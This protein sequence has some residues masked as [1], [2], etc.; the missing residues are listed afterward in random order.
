MLL[1]S[2]ITRGVTL[3]NK[4]NNNMFSPPSRSP[5]KF[6]LNTA[7]KVISSAGLVVAVV[8]FSSGC[9]QKKTDAKTIAVDPSAVTDSTPASAVPPPAVRPQ[10]VS[11]Q[12]SAEVAAPDLGAVNQALHVFIFQR[13]RLP[14]SFEEL[15][16]A[17][18][19]KTMP[20]LPAGKK[21]VIDPASSQVL[22]VN[23]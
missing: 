17:G 22:M 16:S 14:T 8:L 9:G 7:L 15:V 1:K 4:L 2:K 21:L 20:P 3:L 10:P 23:Q 12:A 18:Y 19:V 13:K 11:P 5:A 6:H